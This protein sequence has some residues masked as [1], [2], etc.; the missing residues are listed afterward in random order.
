MPGKRLWV[1]GDIH[2][3]FDPL[4][5]LLRRILLVQQERPSA[6]T[7]I[8]FLGDYIDYGPSSRQVLDALIAL[9]TDFDCVFLAGNHEDLLQ[10]F[11]RRDELYRRFGNI[12][13]R[14]NDGAETVASLCADPALLA[15]L[16]SEEQMPTITP[17]EVHIPEPYLGFFDT[18]AYA[19]CD[20]FANERQALKFAFCHGLLQAEDDPSDTV[21]RPGVAIDE[22]L[23]LRTYSQFH[24]FRRDRNIWIEDLHVWNRDAS[25]GRYGDYILVHGHTPT[26]LLERFQKDTG[27]YDCTSGLPY[28]GFAR[29]GVAVR[30]HDG[31]R[32]QV[33]AS[34][35]ELATIDIDTGAVYG[36]C[37]TALLLDEADLLGDC[38]IS[39]Y[40]VHM[41]RPHRHGQDLTRVEF[42]FLPQ[43]FKA[44]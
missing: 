34:L 13:F 31:F 2:G 23:A 3:M 27:S 35:D 25:P 29:T 9:R 36:K 11:I 14:L 30:R 20:R 4:N 41:D 43:G 33:D 38:T 28:L 17:E 6:Q 32:L 21:T 7:G 42:G 40:Q 22:Q 16:R 15:R 1:I 12:W 26:V 18:L 24:T 19:H 44:E 37:L 8:V 10:Q 5:R 39:A